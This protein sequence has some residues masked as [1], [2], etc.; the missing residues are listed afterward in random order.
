MDAPQPA[1]V[2]QLANLLKSAKRMPGH[3]SLVETNVSQVKELYLIQGNNNA[4]SST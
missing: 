3:R 2:I 4:S 1:C